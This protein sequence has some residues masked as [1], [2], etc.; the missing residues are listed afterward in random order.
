MD[1]HPS[2][3]PGGPGGGPWRLAPINGLTRKLCLL[4]RKFCRSLRAPGW[5]LP[6][7]FPGPPGAGSRRGQRGAPGDG[8]GHTSG[9]EAVRRARR[10]PRTPG[11]CPRIQGR[12]PIGA[13]PGRPQRPRGSAERSQGATGARD[14]PGRDDQRHSRA[15]RL[16]CAVR[17][18]RRA[19]HGRSPA[20]E[21]LRG[22]L[23][24]A[25]APAP[26][27]GTTGPWR[28]P[29]ART[30][31]P[32]AA[33]TWCSRLFRPGTGTSAAGG[34]CWAWTPCP[35]RPG[36]AAST[37]GAGSPRS[38]WPRA[39]PGSGD[40]RTAR[41]APARSRSCWTAVCPPSAGSTGTGPPQRP[42]ATRRTCPPARVPTPPSPSMASS[43]PGAGLHPGPPR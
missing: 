12:Q 41:T 27:A 1:H 10:G 36:R 42:A 29:R 39:A 31:R 30:Y 11:R 26:R 20:A 28:G 32:A 37:W 19:D 33:A 2:G 17:R 24:A 16:R 23:D 9:R 5:P 18:L 25:L 3:G 22:V 6:P 4:L 7:R 34:P 14:R 40:R 15:L 21:G 35:P 8:P 13:S 43:A 38:W